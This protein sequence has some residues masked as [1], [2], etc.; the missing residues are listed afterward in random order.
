MFLCF[1]FFLSRIKDGSFLALTNL[2]TAMSLCRKAV[3]LS[4]TNLVSKSQYIIYLEWMPFKKLP[5]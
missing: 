4:V 5:K 1:N 3:T 2:Y